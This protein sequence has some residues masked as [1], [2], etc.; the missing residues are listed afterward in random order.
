M[1]VATC[2]RRIP[3]NQ[4]GCTFL[5]HWLLHDDSKHKKHQSDFPT[6]TASCNIHYSELGQ[7]LLKYIPVTLHGNGKAINTYAFLDAGSTSTLIEHSLWEELNLSGEKSPL[8][9]SWTGGQN[10]SEKGSVVFSVEISGAHSPEQSFHLRR[11]ILYI[12]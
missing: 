2:E 3:C 12:V 10:R 9:I 1:G 5:H 6:H 7:N 4:N 8:C 11:Y